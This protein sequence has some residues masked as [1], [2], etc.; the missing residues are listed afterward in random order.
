VW[1]ENEWEE[2]FDEAGFSIH[3][4]TK[5][6]GANLA[7]SSCFSPLRRLCFLAKRMLRKNLLS[8]LRNVSGHAQ[9]KQSKNAKCKMQNAKFKQFAKLKRRE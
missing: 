5:N 6:S 9:Q 8:I 4:Q 2:N 7:Y 1:H 3:T